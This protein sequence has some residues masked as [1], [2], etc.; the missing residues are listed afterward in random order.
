MLDK[1]GD[2][3]FPCL[4]PLYTLKKSVC[5]WLTLTQVSDP[6]H[7]LFI[8]LTILVGFSYGST[9][10]YIGARYTLSKAL[11]KFTKFKVA[12]FC[13][14]PHCSMMCRRA[15]MRSEPPLS[16]RNPA[17]SSLITPWGSSFNHAYI[18]LLWTL[19]GHRQQG[20]SSPVGTLI[21]ITFLRYPNNNSSLPFT[22]YSFPLPH[23]VEEGCQF[24]QSNFSQC[25]E[26]FS[27][28]WGFTWAAMVFKLVSGLF[29]FCCCNFW[30]TDC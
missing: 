21:K 12:D 27:H 11:L 10:L 29:D 5:P 7:M 8:M 19:M 13:H 23:T 14:S 28:N 17:C 6:S 15:R 30:D 9:I 22:G 2:S 16:L 1:R 18:K 3:K 26:H 20:D 25:F 24:F 4:T